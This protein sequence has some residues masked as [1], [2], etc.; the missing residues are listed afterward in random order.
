[1]A[2]H[3]ST[4]DTDAGSERYW[5]NTVLIPGGVPARRKGARVSRGVQGRDAVH[6][7]QKE[8]DGSSSEAT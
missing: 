3:I 2:R 4:V 8:G 5:L 6:A 1:M 7:A